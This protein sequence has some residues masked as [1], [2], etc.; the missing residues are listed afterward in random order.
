[1]RIAKMI[2]IC[3]VM[4]PAGTISLY[5]ESDW[6]VATCGHPWVFNGL[7]CLGCL[8]WGAFC[9]FTLLRAMGEKL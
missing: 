9:G 8:A 5:A 7:Y 1:M 6:A 2:A 4:L 3:V